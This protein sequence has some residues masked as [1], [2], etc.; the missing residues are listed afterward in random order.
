VTV[1][2][3]RFAITDLPVRRLGVADLPDCVALAGDRG[4]PPEV[5]KW[6]LIFAVS[7]VMASMTRLADSP[8][9]SS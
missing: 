4:W 5:N 1:Q 8:V 9:P 3:A 7:E 6:R 2:S